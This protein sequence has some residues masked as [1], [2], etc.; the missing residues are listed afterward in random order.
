[1]KDRFIY[2]AELEKNETGGYSVT[3]PDVDGAFTFGD[4]LESSVDKAAEVLQLVIAG[5]LDEGEP[6]PKPRFRGHSDNAFRVAVSVEVSPEIIERVKCM[7]VTEAAKELRVTKGRI[8]Q[9]LDAGI[10]QAVPFGNE[11]LVTIASINARKANP[12]KTGRPSKER[13]QPV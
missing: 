8:C 13:K 9:M 5:L 2:E 7:T 12:G 11:R 3:F 1:M 4:G 10:L 6:L